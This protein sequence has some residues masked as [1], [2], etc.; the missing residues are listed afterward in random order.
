MLMKTIFRFAAFCCALSVAAP[1]LAEDVIALDRTSYTVNEDDGNAYVVVRVARDSGDTITVDFGTANGSAQ[2]GADYQQTVGTLT[3]AGNETAKLIQV[4]LIDDLAAEG[5]EQFTLT[6]SNG[7][8]GTVDPARSTATIDITDNDGSSS[9]IGFDRTNYSVNEAASSVTLTV[10]RQG[11]QTETATVNFATAGSSASENVDYQGRSGT[12]VFQPGVTSQVITVPIFDDGASE[13]NETFLVRL[14]A[15]SPGQAGGSQNYSFGINAA[16]VTIVDNEASTVDFSASAYSVAEEAGNATVTIFRT[17]NTNAALRVNVSTTGGTATSDRDYATVVRTVDFAQGQ[18][19]ATFDIPIFEDQET[20]GTESFQVVLTAAPNSGAA[21]GS[22]SVATVNIIDNE[23]SN[24]VEFA[25]SDFSVSENAGAA[26]VTVRLNRFGNQDQVVTVDYFT[27]TGSATANVDYAPVSGSLT[28]GA[29]ETLKTFAVPIQ[30]DSSTE[31]TETVGLFLRNPSGAALGTNTSSTL[32]IVDDDSA[33]AVQFSNAT[34][35]VSENGGAVTL[36]VLLNRTGSTNSAVS[37]DY[38]TVAGSATTARF[39]S[40]SGTIEFA[41]GSSVAT[42]S[43]PLINDATIQPPQSFNVVLT[44]PRNASLGT[45]SS[46]TVTI[47]DDDG[48]NTVQFDAP[49][50]GVVESDGSVQVRIRAVRGADPNQ[51]LTVRL[52]FGA[53]GDTAELGLD[54]QAPSSTTVTFPAGVN[55][56]NVTIPVTNNFFEAQGVKT[57]TVRLTD[58]GQFT[59]IA[60]QS[61]ARVTIFDDAGPNTVQFLTSTNRFRE[62]DQQAI[63]V[64]VVRFGNFD[65]NG[66]N[67]SFTT[68]LRQGDTAREG[69]NFTE[70]TGTIEFA[71]QLGKLGEDT[72]VVGNETQ[73]TIIIPIPNNN[74]VEGDVTFHLTLTS[75]DV[76]QLG[77][78]TTTQI[79]ITDDDLGNVVE[80]VSPTYSVAESGGNAVLTVRLTPNGDASRASSV[81]YSATQ[82]TAFGG[83]DFSAVNGTLTFAPGE[84]SK[85][86]LIPINNDDIPE[87]SE[88][89]RVTLT[90][91]NPGT[92]VGVQGNAIVTIADDDAENVKPTFQFSSS[93]LTTSNAAGTAN[94]IVTLAR[95]AGTIGNTYAVDYSTTD[96]S[97]AS[98][99][100]YQAV[101]GTL[102]F[103]PGEAAQTIVIPLVPQPAGEPT[104]QFKITLSNPTDGARLGDI[105]EVVISI[106]NPDLATKLANVSTRGPVQQ[107]DGVMIAGFIV[108]G[109]SSKQI[110]VRGSG[111][112][113]TQRGV[114]NAVA[115]T[116]LTLVNGNGDQL[117]YNDDF[118]TN[119]AGD[120]ATL[121]TNELTPGNSREA[122]IVANLGA[123]AYTAILRGKTN[124]IGLVELYDLSPTAA[125]KL[126]NISTR[127]KVEEGNNGAMIAG[128]IVAAPL[129]QPGAPVRVVLRATGPSLR[130]AGVPNAVSDPT[131][132]LYRGSDRI[133]LNDNWKSDQ[134]GEL[135]GTGLAPANSREA[136]IVTDLDPGN[137]TA[138]VRAKGNTT[139]VALVEIYHLEQ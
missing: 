68:E 70:T 90:S 104:R 53:D 123:G 128:F 36:T 116:T 137:Y 93:A 102:V 49:E 81:N 78:I 45:P 6:I 108:T 35:N 130:D 124:G 60:Q 66:T 80:F 15:P 24:T 5:T 84:T 10:V 38:T 77:S 39:V 25:G 21:V 95:G 62:G 83:F 118:G 2:S 11:G 20:E 22:R 33:G 17:G 37:V 23:A 67:V 127:G 122:A 52:A 134:E 135:E 91:P 30:E 113:L 125:S 92:L 57:F 7:Q 101:T 107:G 88:T 138:V 41:P 18:T 119:S 31:D 105:P 106:I 12:L 79:T 54:Y 96:I 74:L 120:L 9:T 14:S 29:G 71:A 129:D 85:T 64:T 103:G 28:F 1:A 133:L 72:V 50:F 114:P 58:P 111:P 46:A 97:A 110:V 86:I 34:Y 109:S 99:R 48:L 44:N 19:A 65:R 42:I 94:V 55:V 82:I 4:P 8:G 63:A 98:G 126:I 89:F 3:F 115:D 136:A 117:A 59:S 56:Q 16:T 32:S 40:T 26:T 121:S 27:S 87:E 139:G 76:A 100:D 132:E 43:V 61:T 131:L 73:K 47:Q 13:G 112:S 69:V 51:V 75:S